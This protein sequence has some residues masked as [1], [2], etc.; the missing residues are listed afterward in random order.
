VCR[1]R[2]GRRKR[3]RRRRRGRWLLCGSESEGKEMEEE[4]I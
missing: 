2:R 1:A 4:V 3:R